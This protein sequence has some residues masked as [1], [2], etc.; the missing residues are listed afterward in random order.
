MTTDVT[1]R[2]AYTECR[3][4][5][6]HFVEG[7]PKAGTTL[8]TPL[9]LLHQNP[10]SSL[11]YRFLLKEMAQDRVVIAL[12]TPGNGMS[13]RPPEAQSIAGYAAAFADGLTALGFGENGSGKVDVF[14]FHSGTYYVSEL[15]VSRPDLIRRPVMSG[16]PFRP[17]DERQSRLESAINH[18]PLTEDGSTVLAQ[19]KYMWDYIVVNRDPRMPLERAAEIFIDH[20]KPLQR[21]SW[22]YVGVWSYP[23]EERLPAITQPTLVIAPNDVTFANCIRAAKLIPH[24]T[25]IEFEDLNASV[26]D[27]AADR[28]ASALRDFLI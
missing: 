16:I 5:Q 22:P 19:F 3:F 4:G 28:Y 7:R 2:R 27:V 15:A 21:S 18:P 13:D 10:S 11:E 9:I 26:F 24:A 6:M 12:D 14:G 17:H 8:K 1:I 20:L 23:A 25:L